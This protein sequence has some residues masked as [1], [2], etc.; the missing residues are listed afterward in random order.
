MLCSVGHYLCHFCQFRHHYDLLCQLAAQIR[1]YTHKITLVQ[2]IVIQLLAA[3]WNKPLLYLPVQVYPADA[4]QWT[5]V[6]YDNDGVVS[7]FSASGVLV[8]IVAAKNHDHA[9]ISGV[10]VDACLPQ[11]RN[12]RSASLS[13]CLIQCLVQLCDR[14]FFCL[15]PAVQKRRI[16]GPWLLKKKV[17]H[18]RLPSVG[19]RSWF[20]FLAVS[21]HV[22]WIINPALG[23]HYFPPG[24]QLPAQPLRGLLPILLLGEHRHDRCE[25]FA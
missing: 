2:W 18:T 13:A 17:V 10:T 5:K 3:R 11:P 4:T 23:C 25:Q 24:L 6:D 21:M 1:R 20:R 22:T 14:P 8:S 19:F 7:D 9:R 12:M 16:L 15:M